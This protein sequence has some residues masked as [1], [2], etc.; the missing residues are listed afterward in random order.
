MPRYKLGF[1]VRNGDVCFFN[2]HEW[3]GNLPIKSN[4]PYERVS[5]VCYYRQNMLNCKSA[6]EELQIIKNRTNLVGLNK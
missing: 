3:H 2:V 1:D 5:I 6:E 4:T